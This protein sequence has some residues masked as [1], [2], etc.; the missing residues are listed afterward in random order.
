MLVEIQ[1]DT[2]FPEGSLEVC[3]ENLKDIHILK[4]KTK[5]SVK[6]R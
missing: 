1:L 3:L 6:V 5:T 4:T 2:I